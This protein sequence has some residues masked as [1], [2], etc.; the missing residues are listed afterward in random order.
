MIQHWYFCL[1][2]LSFTCLLPC[3]R[4]KNKTKLFSNPLLHIRDCSFSSYHIQ[5]WYSK[6]HLLLLAKDN[7]RDFF[8]FFLKSPPQHKTSP[9]HAEEHK[10]WPTRN[11][12]SL[13]QVQIVFL[14]GKILVLSWIPSQL[15][16]RASRSTWELSPWLLSINHDHA[17]ID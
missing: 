5:P 15:G 11:V 14:E 13:F 7:P 8:F 3:I 12:R 16:H 9:S 2:S 17:N 10:T 1:S 6:L 4:A